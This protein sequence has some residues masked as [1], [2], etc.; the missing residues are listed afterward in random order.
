MKNLMFPHGVC[1][2]ATTCLFLISCQKED[3]SALSPSLPNNQAKRSGVSADD[4]KALANVPMI[5]SAQFVTNHNNAFKDTSIN[6]NAIST[7]GRG[8]RDQVVPVVNIISPVAGSSVSGSVTIQTTATD[9]IGVTAVTLF[10][11]GLQIANLATA[12]YHFVWNAS[13]VANGV[14][15]LTATAFDAAGNRS[16]KTISVTVNTVVLPPVELP[17]SFQL[18]MPPVRNQGA[19]GSCVAFAVAYT[20]SCEQY[21]TTGASNYGDLSNIF[22]PEYIFNQVKFSSNCDASALLNSLDLIKNKGVARWQTMPYSDVNGCTLQP[23]SSQD[24][25]AANF[26]ISS[27]ASIADSDIVAIKTMITNRHPVIFSCTIDQSFY[28]ATPGFIWSSSGGNAGSHTLVLCGYDDSKHAYKAIN[29]WGATWGDAGYI[30]I[31]YD[32][33]P[34]VAS[35]YTFAVSL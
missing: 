33:F 9:N 14:Y 3:R 13:Y 17:L 30:W 1:I 24:A 20:R 23:S 32:F 8:K 11:N 26:K 29:S 21:Y 25:E 6:S 16:S 18:L 2:I 34:T 12:P 5:A 27:Y 4:P 22:S 7:T 15:S 35:Y 10:L 28:N 31:D 19:E